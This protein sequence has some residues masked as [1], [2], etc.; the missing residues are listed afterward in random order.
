MQKNGGSLQGGWT[1]DEKILEPVKA[2]KQAPQPDL[3]DAHISDGQTDKVLT[4]HKLS[5][6]DILIIMNITEIKK[7]L[8][9]SKC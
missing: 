1:E 5:S 2:G 8:K 7:Q 9:H 4:T 3:L 6:D